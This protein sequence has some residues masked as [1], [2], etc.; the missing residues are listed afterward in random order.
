M[1]REV[2]IVDHHLGFGGGQLFAYEL[3]T[4]GWLERAAVLTPT[5]SVLATSLAERGVPACLSADE[6]MISI[7]RALLRSRRSERRPDVLLANSLPA[8]VAVSLSVGT[9][10]VL[11]VHSMPGS[12]LR[13]L[14][15]RMVS[16]RFHR[17]LLVSRSL[18]RLGLTRAKTVSLGPRPSDV[19]SNPT[20]EI[21]RSVQFLGRVDYVKGLDLLL[22][23]HRIAREKMPGWNFEYGIAC[24]LQDP[25][26]LV[27]AFA[28]IA[29]NLG[30]TVREGV[31]SAWLR[32][33]GVLAIPSRGEAAC[34][35][36]HEG[37][38]RGMIVVAFSVGG[39]PEILGYG[40]YGV[41]VDQVSPEAFASALVKVQGWGSDQRR[42]MAK[43]AKAVATERAN[44]VYERMV[45][46]ILDD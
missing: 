9:T 23:A 5:G 13:R 4:G 34:L 32:P 38:A 41:L 17:V 43:E 37:M 30:A 31:T 11:V 35:V 45:R 16:M 18:E 44:S 14:V 27:N 25:P 7:W 19:P 3:V 42:A 28:T 20:N 33:G 21:H 22:A 6:S 10:R 24:P 29:A 40:R 1:R 36:A 2:C 12:R 46:A 26:E 15:L 8:A 39:L